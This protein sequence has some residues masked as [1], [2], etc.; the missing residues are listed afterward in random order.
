MQVERVFHV[1]AAECVIINAADE[2]LRRY[3]AT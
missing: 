3:L 1:D 2:E